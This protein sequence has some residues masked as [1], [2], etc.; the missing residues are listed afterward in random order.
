MVRRESKKIDSK[1]VKW[2]WEGSP[3]R[4]MWAGDSRET[5]EHG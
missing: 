2:Q 3:G 1:M 4:I 5:R